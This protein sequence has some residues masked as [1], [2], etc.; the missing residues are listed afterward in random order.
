M[1]PGEERLR[2]CGEVWGGAGPPGRWPGA[3]GRGGGEGPAAAGA[4]L[5]LR[6]GKHG[7]GTGGRGL[8]RESKEEENMGK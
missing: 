7:R 2:V 3:R 6:G 5:R 8:K 4:R 1:L